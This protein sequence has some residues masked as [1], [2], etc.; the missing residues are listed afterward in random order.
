MATKP[1]YESPEVHE[2]QSDL[3]LLWELDQ[4][5]FQIVTQFTKVWATMCLDA[6]NPIVENGE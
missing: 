5:A 6:E 4:H 1:G 2:A 3:A